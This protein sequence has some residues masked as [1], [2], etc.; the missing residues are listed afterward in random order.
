MRMSS[1]TNSNPDNGMDHSKHKMS[2]PIAEKF[3]HATVLFADTAGFT[4]WSSSRQPEQVFQLLEKLFGALDKIALR[5]NVFKVET[6]GDCYMAVTGVPKFQPDH[7]TIMAKFA[8]D[9]L[10]RIRTVLAMLV[11]TLGPDTI[12]LSM[13]IG[14][15]SGEVT[16]GV[17][18]G[19]KS[20]FQLFGDTVNTAARM[21]S[22]GVK[23]RIH[24]SQATA[25][26]LILRGHGNWLVP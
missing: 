25:D 1:M 10:L 2:R 16:A 18:R 23:N 17:L 15:H 14:L 24:C 19:E 6:I 20:R 11:D 22:L 9:S 8:R 12:E 5:R 7:A 13:R 21:E 4:Q 3:A 26:E